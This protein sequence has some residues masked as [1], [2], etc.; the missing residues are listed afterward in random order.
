MR[1]E[2]DVFGSLI[3][4]AFEDENIRAIV[5]N[6]SRGDPSRVPDTLSDYDVAIFVRDFEAMRDDRWLDRFG[7][8]MVRWPVRP[9]ETLGPDWI[10]Q[11]ALFRD[12][13]RVDFQFAATTTSEIER[14]GPFHCVLLDKDQLSEQLRGIPVAGTTIQLPTEDEFID[15]INAFW[16]DIPYVAKAL[17]RG[18]LDYARYTLESDLRFNKLHPLIRW[19]IALEHGPDTDT[20]LFGRWFQ[21]YLPE[22][23]RSAYLETYAGA[24]FHDQWRAMFAAARFAGSIGRRVAGDCNYSYPDETEQNVQ[25]Y[26]HSLVESSNRP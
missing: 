5:I 9:M 8:V 26:L 10:T 18:E 22:D 13:V 15:R 7:E 1:S 3:D 23:L 16:W 6:G 11:L 20:G 17:A 21:R 25:A 19:H 14:S 12:G 4:W 2:T 24:E